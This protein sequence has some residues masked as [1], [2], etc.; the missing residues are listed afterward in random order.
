MPRY[1][2]TTAS[3]GA[4]GGGETGALTIINSVNRQSGIK[5]TCEEVIGLMRKQQV[6]HQ[7][8]GDDKNNNGGGGIWTVQVKDD[9]EEEMVH[10]QWLQ[11]VINMAMNCLTINVGANLC[12]R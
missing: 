4:Q 9:K 2:T 5:Q 10:I 6:K 8:G 3:R 7:C 1:M 12:M 11:S